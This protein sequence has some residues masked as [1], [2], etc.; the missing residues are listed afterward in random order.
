M[1]FNKYLF[2]LATVS[3][4]ALPIFSQKALSQECPFDSYIIVGG[5]CHNMTVEK[6]PPT[7]HTTIYHDPYAS[8]EVRDFTSQSQKKECRDFEYQETAQ[9]H[10]DRYPE[11]KHL[12]S[13]YAARS[14]DRDGYACDNLTRL[15]D[16]ILTPAIWNELLS[17]NIHRKQSTKNVESL[18]RSEVI[19]IIGFYP[20]ASKGSRTIWSDPINNMSIQI[21]FHEGKIMDMKGI[22]F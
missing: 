4:S 20:N 14:L 15:D 17:K 9:R 5:R 16:D 21:R 7:V 8:N 1:K 18:S 12:D 13:D 6:S 11:Q 3:I 10:F 19:D 22:G 2:L